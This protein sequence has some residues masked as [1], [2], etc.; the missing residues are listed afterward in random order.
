MKVKR[1]GK[2]TNKIG[3]QYEQARISRICQY[4]YDSK[5]RQGAGP[6]QS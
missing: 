5:R 4:V 6:R 1:R 2:V 3:K